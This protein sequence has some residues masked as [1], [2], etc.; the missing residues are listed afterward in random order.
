MGGI[1]LALH[2]QQPLV[3]TPSYCAITK[4]FCVLFLNNTKSPFRNGDTTVR[5]VWTK[6]G[7]GGI[8]RS[9]KA[10]VPEEACQS[11]GGGITGG[12]EAER[13]ENVR[14][15]TCTHTP[16]TQTP[17]KQPRGLWLAY[18][19]RCREEWPKSAPFFFSATLLDL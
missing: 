7:R 13:P 6:T 9:E 2:G 5:S 11:A 12:S 1:V 10:K 14:A 18:P 17:N 8:R 15:H 4:Q 16:S 19:L 3:K